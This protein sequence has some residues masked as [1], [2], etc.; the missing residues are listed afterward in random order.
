[1]KG[2]DKTKRKTNVPDLSNDKTMICRMNGM[3]GLLNSPHS[4]TVLRCLNGYF[5]SLFL[6]QDAVSGLI[7]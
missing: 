6:C 3:N 7:L 2:R 4:I 5:R 1:M